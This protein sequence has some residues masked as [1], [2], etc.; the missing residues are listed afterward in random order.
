MQPRSPRECRR[1]AGPAGGLRHLRRA[2]GGSAQLIREERQRDGRRQLREGIHRE[3][4]DDDGHESAHRLTFEAPDAQGQQHHD[5]DVE[6]QS[7]EEDR[8]IP[9]DEPQG[10]VGA[11]VAVEPRADHDE[12]GGDRRQES[13]VGRRQP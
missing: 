6:R 5:R 3:D 7:V 13:P 1:P 2:V 11:F 8:V 12:T 4:G 10:E 9:G